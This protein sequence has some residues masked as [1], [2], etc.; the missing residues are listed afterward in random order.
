M[1]ALPISP[2][3]APAVALV[4]VGALTLAPA[5]LA[6]AAPVPR[7]HVHIENLQLAGIGQDV[8]YAITPWVQYAVGGVSYLINFTPLIGGP[9]AAQI[10]INYFQGI[11]PTVEATVN[12][13]AAVVQDPLNFFPTTAAYAGTLFDIGYNL[14]SAQLMFLGFPPLEPLA[15]GAASVS[16]PAGVVTRAAAAVTAVD[17]ASDPQTPE[18]AVRPDL[19]DSTPKPAR[20]SRRGGHTTPRPARVAAAAAAQSAAEVPSPRIAK[21]AAR[22]A[23]AAR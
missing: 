1:V 21:A 3:K 13:L 15:Q 2:L 19:R 12:Y 6:P 7:A 8:Y 4:A 23:R 16:P 22:S 9:I 11:Q 17:A 14:L 10:N 20:E 5:T 18:T